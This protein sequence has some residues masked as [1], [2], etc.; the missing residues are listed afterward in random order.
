MGGKSKKPA[1]PTKSDEEKAAEKAAKSRAKAAADML[2]AAKEGDRAKVEKGLAAGVDIN[3]TNER[4]QTAAH[5]AAAFGHRKLLRILHAKGAD[6]T[7]QTNDHNKFTPLTAALFIGEQASAT[8]I[9]ALI[10]GKDVKGESDDSDD[11]DDDEDAD[12]APEGASGT[13]ASGQ[14]VSIA[15]GKPRRANLGSAM[16]AA[17][18]ADDVQDTAEGELI[19][20]AAHIS[21][22]SDAIDK[23]Q[24]DK[25]QYR[26]L[27]LTNGLQ[28]MLVSDA[29]CDYASA[30]MDVGVGSSSDPDS[31]PGL[32]HLCEHMLFLGTDKYPN[33][34]EY[35]TYL[36][37]HGGESNAFTAH[38]DTHYFFDVQ[39]R[40][41]RGA[42][43]RFAQFF[44]CPRFTEDA[45][46]RELKAV[47]SEFNKNKL[48]D[49]WRVQQVS[50]LLA[51]PRHPWSRF[52]AGNLST[53]S[54]LPAVSA[55]KLNDAPV[56]SEGS[57]RNALLRFH[58]T[59]YSAS[60][61]SLAV[62]GRESLDALQ[63][64]VV[65]LFAP[66]QTHAPLPL[67]RYPHPPYPDECLRRYLR[68][69]PM[70]EHSF[71]TVTW[72]IAPIR[73]QYLSKPFRYVSHILGHEGEGSLLAYLKGLGWAE[74]LLAGETHSHSDFAT[75]VVTITLT[76]AGDAH[77]DKMVALVYSCLAMIRSVQ[78][79]RWIFD[80]IGGVSR[81]RLAFLDAVD[82]AQATLHMAQAL[83]QV[84]ARHAL[85]GSFLY[86]VWAPEQIS[87]LLA[88]LSPQHAN[89]V[90]VSPRHAT[91]AMQREPWYGTAYSIAAIS[92][93]LMA[94]CESPPQQAALRWPEPNP[95]IPSDFALVC[96]T[97]PATE[98]AAAPAVAAPVTPM[99]ESGSSTLAAALASRGVLSAPLLIH[100]DAVLEVWHKVDRTFR[101]PKS[102]LYMDVVAPAAYTSPASAML[103]ALTFRLIVDDLT[104]FAYPAEIAGLTYMVRRHTTGFYIVVEGMSHKLPLLLAKVAE[105]LATPALDEWRFDTQRELEL[106]SLRSW[107]R[108]A[109]REHARYAS[110]HLLERQRWHILEYLDAMGSGCA[111]VD[112]PAHH[113]ALR[114]GMRATALCHGNT[115]STSAVEMLSQTSTVLGGLPVDPLQLPDPRCLA[116]REGE[117][118]VVR[119][120]R[121]LCPEAH[122]QWLLDEE[123]NSA[124][125][126]TLQG[127]MD[128]RPASQI[129]ELLACI[130]ANG[131]FDTLRTN[132]QLG[133]LVDLGVRYDHGVYGLKVT[134]QSAS[135]GPVYLDERIEAFLASVSTRLAQLSAEE[136]ANHRDSLV[137]RRL[138]PPKTLRDESGAH[139]SEITKATYHFTRDEEVAAAAAALTREDLV[140]YWAEHFD[141]AA[142][143]RR[144][145]SSHVYAPRNELPTKLESGI[146]GRRIVY[147]DGLEEVLAF[148]RTLNAFPA[149][150]RRSKAV[151]TGGESR[152]PAVPLE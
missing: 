14:L 109:P 111:W 121:S 93:E 25:R 41:L 88:Q 118:V 107:F 105:R 149:A 145:L 94:E 59:H 122:K 8:L 49:A 85:V 47:D 68:V 42:L 91:T 96:D 66:V 62:L 131:A 80:E 136:F 11:S 17:A 71:L 45:T 99:D 54:D 139:W 129:V 36:E 110:A 73:D 140:R 19:D 61:M 132:E 104:E 76:E 127:E 29:T 34:D 58:S 82:P 38:E 67:P 113:A 15:K 123:T 4:G 98:S 87:D 56:A 30:A 92:E 24:N 79:P 148:K 103:T 2:K 97:I 101:R 65:P 141:A 60:R 40:Y 147:V 10:A 37:R 126:L 144:K 22:S 21:E 57:L 81:M 50:R 151:R 86:D 114:S 78:S 55:L 138:E 90:H 133:Y 20:T 33:E 128:E 102:H 46:E 152:P 52:D 115:D 63:Q 64:L 39:Q 18:E 142:S 116:L 31:L 32:A 74:E 27:R 125:E 135:H 26:W 44:L 70:K 5:Y 150:P 16:A 1:T 112:M 69:V 72:A 48:N 23:G 106:K 124:V 51:D 100:D 143:K 120:H 6:F 89:I 35:T 75:F 12:D 134:V 84:P 95:F 3:H 119:T 83:Q 43:D 117:E 137:K 28:V 130:L 108:G 53:L 13:S 77:V 7:L 146:G 9:E